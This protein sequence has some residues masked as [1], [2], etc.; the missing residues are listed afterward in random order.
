MAINNVQD[1]Y[2]TLSVMAP[3]R[4]LHLSSGEFARMFTGVYTPQAFCT[5]SGAQMHLSSDEGQWVCFFWHTG[6]T[7]P[8]GP[9]LGGGKPFGGV[10][11]DLD[12]S[13]LTGHAEL[14]AGVV[15][16][17]FRPIPHENATFVYDWET[18]MWQD[19]TPKDDVGA[20]GGAH[21]EE[22]KLSL[23][24]FQRLNAIRAAIGRTNHKT[25]RP[26]DCANWTLSDWAVAM[27][28]EAGE[29]LEAAMGYSLSVAKAQG[30]VKRTVRGDYA[31]PDTAREALAAELCDAL[32]YLTL[33]AT[34]AGI[35]D[36]GRA[37]VPKWNEVSER[38]AYPGHLRDDGTPFHKETKT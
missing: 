15:Q 24:V 16:R 25:G 37:I 29:V 5:Q 38:M 20:V 30:I 23:S 7:R 14:A 11:T 10:V 2:A 13:S 21:R 22:S 27:G 26:M 12:R 19:T 28:E 9:L 36:L 6:T 3:Y 32:V 35:E 34:A 4:R 33:V 17:T 1:L 18:G 8:P 31:D